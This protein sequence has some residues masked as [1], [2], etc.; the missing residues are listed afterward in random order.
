MHPNEGI[1]NAGGVY[2]MHKCVHT[3]H[4]YSA[5]VENQDKEKR[6]LPLW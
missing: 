4:G 1:A 5:G 2:G 6:R 3:V